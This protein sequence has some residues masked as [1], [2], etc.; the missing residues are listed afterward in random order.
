MVEPGGVLQLQCGCDELVYHF[1]EIVVMARWIVLDLLH[2]GTG[3]I[4]SSPQ[5]YPVCT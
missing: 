3:M 5:I 1:V 2:K 4:I